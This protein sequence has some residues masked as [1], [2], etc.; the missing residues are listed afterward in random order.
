MLKGFIE[1]L[2]RRRLRFHEQRVARA[3]PR[4]KESWELLRRAAQAMIR[5][6]GELASDD[7]VPEL[8]RLLKES[9]QRCCRH[10]QPGL[11]QLL[12]EEVCLWLG[13]RFCELMPRASQ[14]LWNLLPV[15]QTVKPHWRSAAF[16]R[17]VSRC[18]IFGFDAECLV[19]CRSALEG[20]FEAAISDSDCRRVVGERHWSGRLAHSVYDLPPRIAVAKRLGRVRTAAAADAEKVRAAARH[21]VHRKPR[22]VRDPLNYIKKTVAVIGALGER[23]ECAGPQRQ[24]E[25]R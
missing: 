19:M 21:V 3:G 8:R 22:V 20:A 2:A 24:G 12:D 4:A 10:H 11:V 6:A 13:Q 9:A 25:N 15:T 5:G 18:Y 17:R 1:E 16:L 23:G 7:S 14:R